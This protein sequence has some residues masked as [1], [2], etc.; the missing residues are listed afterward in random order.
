VVVFL[1]K[2]SVALLDILDEAVLGRHL[3]VILL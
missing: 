2:L 1:K 3:V